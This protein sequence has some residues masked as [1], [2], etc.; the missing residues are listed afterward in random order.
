MDSAW[1][2][3]AV[4]AK[5]LGLY[6]QKTVSQ[7]IYGQRFDL[8]LVDVDEFCKKYFLK[9]NQIEIDSERSY[10]DG[11]NIKVSGDINKTTAELQS[12]INLAKLRRTQAE[13]FELEQ[14]KKLKQKF[15]GL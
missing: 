11:T 12:E 4:E 3:L 10:Y 7:D 6:T 5:A 13:S 2:A 8:F 9:Y 14:Y 1:E 15:G